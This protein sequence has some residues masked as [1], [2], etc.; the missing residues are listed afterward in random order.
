M[1]IFGIG[2]DELLVIMLLAAI[3]LGPERLARL[4]REA[5]KLIRDLRAYFGSLSDEL[6]NELDVL[7]ELRDVKREINHVLDD[8]GS[9]HKTPHI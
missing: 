9:N 4:A 2:T 7:D 8:V 5:G 6:K 3:V 1:D